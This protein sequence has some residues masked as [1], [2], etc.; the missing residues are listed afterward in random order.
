[1]RDTT[2]DTV[3]EEKQDMLF[4]A[5]INS[6]VAAALM[7]ST[8]DDDSQGKKKK[9]YICGLSVKN[10]TTVWNVIA[11]PML[12]FITC[13]INF[14]SMAFIPLLLSSPDYFA[15]ESSNLGR[16]TALTLIWACLL[17]LLLTPFMTFVYEGIGRR[18]PVAYSLL[19]TNVL[20]WLMP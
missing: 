18:I 14:Y 4:A 11:M 3:F 13:T 20:I 12:P 5:S 6:D 10:D 2:I 8:H 1:M 17:P 16:A 9:R 15:I 19:A 7:D